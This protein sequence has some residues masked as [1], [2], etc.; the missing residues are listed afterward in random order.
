MPFL[1]IPGAVS[2]P[3]PPPPAA[4]IEEN[5]ELLP[6]APGNVLDAFPG[7]TP[8]PPTVIE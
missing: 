4:V 7:A 3:P 5:I 8:P 1:L 6:F 2:E